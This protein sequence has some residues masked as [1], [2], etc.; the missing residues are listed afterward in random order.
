LE[1]SKHQ[2]QHVKDCT[3]GN[4]SD[5][6]H[7]IYLLLAEKL[8]KNRNTEYANTHRLQQDHPCVLDLIRKNYLKKPWGPEVPFDLHNP[9]TADPS[10]GQAK[11]IM[12]ILRNQANG[13]F[14]ECG[15]S[16]GEFLSNTLYMERYKNWTGLLIE[17]D[18]GS[19]DSLLTRKRKATHVPACLSLETYPTE[20]G[21]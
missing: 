17:P 3:L 16:D 2:S 8:I 21:V 11:A 18:R 7:F 15:A 5:Y 4:I 19:Y 12:R 6:R 1:E 20:V 10:A 14:V 13:F 9:K